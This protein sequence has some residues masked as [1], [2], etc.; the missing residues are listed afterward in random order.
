MDLKDDIQRVK[1]EGSLQQAGTKFLVPCFTH[2]IGS[3]QYGVQI[4]FEIT[5]VEAS[6]RGISFL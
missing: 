4:S 6:V 2:D 1:P 5:N 3:E